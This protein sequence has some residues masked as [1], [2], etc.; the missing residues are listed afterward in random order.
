MEELARK[1]KLWG[2]YK[3]IKT[4][5]YNLQYLELFYILLTGTTGVCIS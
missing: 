4:K 1:V 2:S 3:V 5:F